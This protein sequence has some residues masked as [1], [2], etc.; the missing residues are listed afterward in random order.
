MGL[1]II[2]YTKANK[3][4]LLV[5]DNQKANESL[6]NAI[7]YLDRWNYNTSIYNTPLCFLPNELRKYAKQSISDWKN[8]FHSDCDKCLLKSECSGFFSWNLKNAEVYPILAI[9]E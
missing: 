6:K 8:S 3:D 2:G 1:E 7:L 5:D 9:E 4:L